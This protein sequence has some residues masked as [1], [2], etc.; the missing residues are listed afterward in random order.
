MSELIE[1]RIAEHNGNLVKIIGDGLLVE[2]ACGTDI[3]LR[4]Q[5]SILR[6]RAGFGL[7]PRIR[8]HCW[9]AIGANF[10]LGSMEQGNN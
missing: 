9:L 2:F 10:A 7:A 8:D 5:V 6:R 3:V 1:P 4:H